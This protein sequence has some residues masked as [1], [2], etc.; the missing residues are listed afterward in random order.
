MDREAW[1]T[2]RGVT[3]SDMTEVTE[4]AHPSSKLKFESVEDFPL[5][6]QCS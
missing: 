3:K 4:H 6:F 2:V 1:A 5:G